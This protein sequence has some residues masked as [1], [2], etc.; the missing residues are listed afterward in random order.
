MN[1]DT[2]KQNTKTLYYVVPMLFMMSGNKFSV[3]QK[4]VSLHELSRSYIFCHRKLRQ[5]FANIN[6]I[7]P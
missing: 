3:F 1:T 5:I 7:P 6:S 2:R 4:V